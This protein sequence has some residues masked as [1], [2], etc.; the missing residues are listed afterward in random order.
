MGKTHQSKNSQELAQLFERISKGEDN[1]L[2]KK[3]ALR[4]I[5]SI[6][7]DEI[8]LAEQNLIEHGYP[9]H[10]VQQLSATFMLMGILED[11][12][13]NMCKKLPPNHILRLVIAEHDL[14]MC[15][16]SD[17]EDTAKAISQSPRLTD[18]SSQFRKLC[19]I[20]EHLD[21]MEEHIEREEDV[22]FP[23]L[24][25]HG[26]TSLCRAAHDDHNYI[27]AAICDL[28]EIVTSFKPEN[29]KEFKTRLNS[30]TKYLCPILR[31]HIS[32]EDK[33]LYPIA[34]EVIKDPKVWSQI[35][36]VCDDIGYC[37]VHM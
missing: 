21:S 28:I 31:E 37:G 5:G 30:I 22:I 23:Y 13:A 8:T 36:E 18:T 29:I 26:W 19:H 34:L 12:G 35:K 1:T 7:P 25:K 15:F 33:I 6:C 2:L 3:E 11:Q 20:I 4:L 16:I 14:L 10:L 27:R 17:L 24:K 9:A 32:Q